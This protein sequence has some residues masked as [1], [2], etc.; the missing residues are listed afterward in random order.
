M[1]PGHPG[2]GWDILIVARPA[3]TTATFDE[4]RGAL[5]RLL[6]SLRA[7]RKTMS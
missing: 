4:F 5:Q 7:P 3:C 1:T 2:S 6:D